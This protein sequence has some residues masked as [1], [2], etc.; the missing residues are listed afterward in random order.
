[1]VAHIDDCERSVLNAEFGEC[2]GDGSDE[3]DETGPDV[4]V[5]AYDVW[6]EQPADFV[7]AEGEKENR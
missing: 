2:F 3:Q 5:I 4:I 6:M 7:V 1:M